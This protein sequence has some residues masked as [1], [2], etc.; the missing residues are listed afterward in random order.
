MWMLRTGLFGRLQVADYRNGGD[1]LNPR[2][3]TTK[4]WLTVIWVVR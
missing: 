4:L 2:A 1:P 3:D